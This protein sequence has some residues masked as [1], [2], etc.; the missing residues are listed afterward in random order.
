MSSSAQDLEKARATGQALP[1]W[2]STGPGTQ[3]SKQHGSRRRRRVKK[4]SAIVEVSMLGA[5]SL[6]GTSTGICWPE[7]SQRPR[8]SLA[9]PSAPITLRCMRLKP[10][11]PTSAPR[12]PAKVYRAPPHDMLCKTHMPARLASAL[13]R[14]AAIGAASVSLASMA[15][16]ARGLLGRREPPWPPWHGLHGLHGIRGLHGLRGLRGLRGLHGLLE[17][18]S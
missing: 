14:H 9:H 13:G 15:S 16:L 10:S 1:G 4:I 7:P 2:S 18:A 11:L 12:P 5:P 3:L 8:L 6:G 17:M